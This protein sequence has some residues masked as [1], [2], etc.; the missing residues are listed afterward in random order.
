MPC[1]SKSTPRSLLHLAPRGS[2]A[3]RSAA[4]VSFPPIADNGCHATQKRCAGLLTRLRRLAGRRCQGAA[5]ILLEAPCFSLQL[6]GWSVG[7]IAHF[8]RAVQL[9]RGSLGCFLAD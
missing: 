7:V 5:E 4:N 3:I 8:A 6:V 2:F 9:L 1:T